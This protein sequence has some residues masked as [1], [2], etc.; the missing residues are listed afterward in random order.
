MTMVDSKTMLINSGEGVDH[1]D[2]NKVVY[3][4]TQRAWEW[5]GYAD[6][7]AH[8]PITSSNYQTIFD[9]A[10]NLGQTVFSKGG[11]PHLEF[12]GLDVRVQQGFLGMYTKTAPPTVLDPGM[13]W[14]YVTGTQT[15]THVAA[16]GGQKRYDYITL[17]IAETDG[18]SESRDFKDAVTYALSTSTPNKRRK[19]VGTL[20]IIQGTANASPTV[21]V[22][23]GTEKVVAL[24]LVNDTAVEKVWDCTQPAGP[25]MTVVSCPSRD[26]VLVPSGNWAPDTV[27]P[28][29]IVCSTTGAGI[30]PPSAFAGDPMTKVIGIE[31][32]TTLTAGFI[33]KMVQFESGVSLPTVLDDIS[34]LFTSGT[35]AVRLDFRGF[36]TTVGATTGP[37]WCH[38]GRSKLGQLAGAGTQ[39]GMTVALQ[40]AGGAIGD[41]VLWARWILARG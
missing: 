21:P 1:D 14:I 22:P 32:K 35:H 29:A 37:Y 26:L 9:G 39:S 24:V 27:A 20:A 11:A 38:G 13:R 5:P 28:G 4:A 41:K 18:D 30:L 31:M 3:G 23:G 7:L 12:T 25:A 6:A 33:I 34:S 10:T 2:M 19:L 15:M 36:P 8:A 17:S 40:V 16:P